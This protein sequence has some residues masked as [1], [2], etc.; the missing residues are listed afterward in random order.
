VLSEEV[1][2]KVI[3]ITYKGLAITVT[4]IQDL[5]MRYAHRPHEPQ[6]AYGKQSIQKLNRKNRALENIPV[7]GKD[8]LG[9]QRELRQYGVDYAVTTRKTEP[10]VFDIY[11]K[12]G[13]INQI[14]SALQTYAWNHFHRLQRSTIQDRMRSAADRAQRHSS[15]SPIRQQ[16]QSLSQSP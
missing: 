9:L 12:G 6:Q 4:V 15:Q 1:Q 10:G 5:I 2:S 3:H 13:D 8:L 11:F 7:S 14:Q 16:Q